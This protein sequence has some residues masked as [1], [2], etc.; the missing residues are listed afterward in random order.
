MR[1]QTVGAASAANSADHDEAS[2]IPGAGWSGPILNKTTSNHAGGLTM[3]SKNEYRYKTFTTKL[4][5]RDMQFHKSAPRAGEPFPDFRLET[6]DGHI[7]SKQDYID[8]K[9]LLL[10]FGSLTCP[11]TASAMPRLER[12]YNS[13]GDKVEFVLLNVREAHPGEYL[14]QPETLESK[15]EHAR[16]LKQLYGLHWTVVSDDIDGS[17]HRALDPKPNAV[18]IMSRTGDV[19]FRSLWASDEEPLAEALDRLVQDKP[20][21]KTQ[22]QNLLLPVIRAMGVVNEVMQRGGPAAVRDLWLA[23]F[24]MA[25]AGKLASLLTPLS[26]DARGIASVSTLGV[27]MAVAIGLVWYWL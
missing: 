7:I 27:G 17:L 15:M 25:L 5:L 23:G 8:N 10:V 14:P 12:L 20:L 2:R 24:P 26:A 6:T 19:V 16:Q 11:M 21:V 4:L 1:A 3:T 22:S 18:F 9:P 13:F